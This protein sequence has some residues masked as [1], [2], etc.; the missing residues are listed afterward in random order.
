MS[1]YERVHKVLAE[2][3]AIGKNS[4]AP[5]NMG[6]Y[7]F[8][9]IE[10]ITNALKPL[11]AKHGVFMVPTVVERQE[12]GRTIGNGKTMWVVD[13]LV[14]FT[15][16]SVDDPKLF[17]TSKPGQS[18]EHTSWFQDHFTAEVWGQGTDMGDKATQKAMTS[19]FK[20]MLAVTFCISDSD[21]DAEAH[22]VPESSGGVQRRGEAS[23]PAAVAPG[24]Q[25]APPPSD[26]PVASALRVT[27]GLVRV[28]ALLADKV[29]VAD[30]RYAR[31]LP[32]LAEGISEPDMAGW[33]QLLDELEAELIAKANA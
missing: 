33:E 21:S 11:L 25:P 23:A 20:S 13:L 1:V 2:L 30:A 6:G 12:S 29:P 24:G 22:D 16:Y 26:V 17:S 15:F 28:R 27:N 14:R 10:D 4:V 9:G 18:D 5:G 7:R 3:P 8:R 31:G 32:K 19:A